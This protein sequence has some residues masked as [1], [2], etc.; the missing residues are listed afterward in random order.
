MNR[1]VIIASVLSYTLTFLLIL[2]LFGLD[3]SDKMLLNGFERNLLPAIAIGL[4][5]TFFQKWVMKN[6]KHI[7]N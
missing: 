1:F 4:F 6:Q 5:L 7:D 2:V 3:V